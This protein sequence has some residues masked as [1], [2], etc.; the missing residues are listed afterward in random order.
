[1]GLLDNTTNTIIIDA[2]LTDLGRQ[3]L[4]KNDGSF[5]IAKFALADDEVNYNIIEKYGISVGTEKIEK[6]T[7]VFEAVTNHNQ[8]QKYKLISVSNPNLT[9]LPNLYLEGNTSAVIELSR[10]STRLQNVTVKQNLS[11]QQETIDVEFQDQVFSVELSNQFLQINSASPVNI[12][13][14]QRA[15]YKLGATSVS[16][17]GSSVS[18]GI[19]LKSIS[20]SMFQVYGNFSNKNII[21]TIVKV[22]GMQ[23]GAVFEFKININKNT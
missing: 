2:V 22:T 20:D 16:P 14:S 3:L 9:K 17:N 4:A 7:S 15:L 19:R 18:F 8:A 10:N 21:S 23:S 13:S 12:D 6:N 5:N 1:M 11:N